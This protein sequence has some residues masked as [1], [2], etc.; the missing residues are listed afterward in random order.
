MEGM[1]FEDLAELLKPC[2]ANEFLA[3]S[4]GKSYRHVRG[5]RGKFALM[6]P[7]D[8]LN[9]ILMTHRLDYPRLR[10]M[11]DGKSLPTSSF[12]LHVNVGKG[13]SPIPR[14]LH[15]ELESKLRSGATLVLDAVDELYEPI[16]KLASGLERV[17]HERVQVNCYA[18]WKVSRGFDLH[19]DDHDVFIVQVAG[20]K[21]WNVYGMTTPYPLKGTGEPI[22]KPTNE[23][24]WS[25][26][27]EDGDVLYIPRGWWH[28]AVPLDE[29][30]LHLTV[31]IHNRT[32]IDLFRWLSDSLRSSE[33]YRK[34]LPRFESPEVR[35]EHMETLRKELLEKWNAELLENYFS[36]LDA[37]AEPR[38]SFGL[39]F[40]ATSETLEDDSVLRINT[41][42]QLDLK[43]TDGVL[44]FACN[45]KQ[46]KFG[47]E[48]LSVISALNER[49]T[50]SVSELCEI[51]NE[52]LDQKTVRMFLLE[53]VVN[54]L[55]VRVKR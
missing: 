44:E 31:G 50:C 21:R 3:S 51:A 33:T 9:E 1:E 29:P 36:D 49:R 11:Q 53:L 19:W 55:V 28:V 34:D 13:K 24:I 6:L 15:V 26:T 39:P 45:K 16:K 10:L 27:L 42:R 52:E 8:A 5:T 20:R 2:L 41:P 40:S 14:L 54:G 38:A 46:W 18:G 30:T 32:G 12:I 23:P 22:P 47:K 25:E 4:W 7:W 37:T 43:I 35:S 17:F 48:A